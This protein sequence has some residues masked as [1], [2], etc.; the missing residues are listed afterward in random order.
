MGI[1]VRVFRSGI[2]GNCFCRICRN[3]I[4]R[5]DCPVR[6]K[7]LRQPDRSLFHTLGIFKKG[8]LAGCCHQS[9]RRYFQCYQPRLPRLYPRSSLK[10]IESMHF[11]DLHEYAIDARLKCVNFMCENADNLSRIVGACKSPY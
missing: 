4:I 8:A 9:G 2:E 6:S 1:G 11:E 7:N 3:S 10:S 5:E